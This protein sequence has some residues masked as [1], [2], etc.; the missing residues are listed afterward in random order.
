MLLL[1]AKP[2]HKV[3]LLFLQGGMLSVHKPA[4]CHREQKE[5]AGEEE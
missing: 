1:A 3:L 2:L 5:G 4:V